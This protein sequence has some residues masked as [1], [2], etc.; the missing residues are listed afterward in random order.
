MLPEDFQ[1]SQAS[2]Q[3]FVDCPR[4][5]KLRYLDRLS[6]P[7]VVSEP[8]EAQERRMA[9][10]ASFHRLVQQHVAGVPESLIGNQVDDPQLR[11]W[12]ENYMTFRP[13]AAL[14]GVEPAPVV[15][16][17]IVLSCWIDTHRLIAKFDVLAIVPGKRGVIIDWKTSQ[18]RPRDRVL[19]NRLQTRVYPYV[20]A[21]ALPAMGERYRLDLEQIEMIYWFPSAPEHPFRLTYSTAQHRATR[22]LLEELIQQIEAP[23]ESFPMTEDVGLCRL[24]RYRSYCARGG[25]A[26]LADPSVEVEMEEDDLDGFDIDFD[27]VAEVEL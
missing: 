10:G 18:R 11:M 3:D 9:L 19:E 22:A 15:H 7:A 4:R 2:L 21:E 6:W 27:Q 14:V 24:C 13:I 26:G 25:P 20:A 16:S 23:G 17:E 1:F 5:F 12:W 8:V